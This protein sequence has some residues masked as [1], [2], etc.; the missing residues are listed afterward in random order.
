MPRDAQPAKHE[1]MP[2]RSAADDLANK[3]LRYTSTGRFELVLFSEPAQP[4]RSLGSMNTTVQVIG[5]SVYH[6]C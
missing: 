4:V 6:F 5:S 2:V 3:M 1:E